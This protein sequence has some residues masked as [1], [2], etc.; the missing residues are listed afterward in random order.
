MHN[1]NVTPF[2]M[3]KDS[4]LTPERYSKY[5]YIYNATRDLP[6]HQRAEMMTELMDAAHGVTVGDAIDLA[7]NPQ[8]YH[9]ELWQN[10]LKEAWR[11]A[12]AKATTRDAGLLEQLIEHWNRRSDADS[13]GALAFYA[14]KKGLGENLAKKVEPPSD[15]T[16]EQ[17]LEA[18]QKAADWLK[19]TFAKGVRVQYGHYFRVGRQGGTTTWPVSGGTVSDA[20]MATVRAIG[21]SA[22]REN[23]MV[24]HSGQTSTQIVIMTDPPESYTLVPLGVSDHQDSGHWD[25]QADQLFSKSRPVRTYFLNRAE[26]LK[27]V[28]SAKTLNCN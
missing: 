10:R 22:V 24:G 7:F 14:F 6:R 15:L 5:P 16:D 13:E 27:H 17:V 18:V 26:L 9:A 20:G 2:A 4:P 25:D 3:M 11:R 28:T 23:E 1:N 19:R 12:P 21:F 8:V